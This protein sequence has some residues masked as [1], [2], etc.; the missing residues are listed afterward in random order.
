[1][2]KEENNKLKHEMSEK[3]VLMNSL[4]RQLNEDGQ[5][6]YDKQKTVK[7]KNIHLNK[8]YHQKQKIDSLHLKTLKMKCQI[9]KQKNYKAKQILQHCHHIYVKQ[10][11][12]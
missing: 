8:I 10:V 2:L 7:C 6:K 5:D 12:L 1:M 3:K 9:K 11:K 4:I